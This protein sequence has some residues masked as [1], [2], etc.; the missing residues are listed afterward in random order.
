MTGTKSFDFCFL[1]QR[2]PDIL[3]SPPSISPGSIPLH[4]PIRQPKQKPLDLQVSPAAGKKPPDAGSRCCAN[5]DTRPDRQT[6]SA[7][8]WNGSSQG[9]SSPASRSISGARIAGSGNPTMRKKKGEK[10][11]APH[12]GPTRDPAPASDVGEPNEFTS[13][14]R[15]NKPHKRASTAQP[16]C[17]INT[18]G[19]KGPAGKRTLSP[20]AS[21][22]R[23]RPRPI[24]WLMQK[25][26]LTMATPRAFLQGAQPRDLEGGGQKAR[27]AGQ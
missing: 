5:R 16:A 11:K 4:N 25:G 15:H 2:R 27:P 3:R 26:I 13:T 21:I 1:P 23:R 22:S 20:P 6:L 17:G 18:A 9:C 7:T 24:H 19:C 10:A 14:S 8:I 12:P